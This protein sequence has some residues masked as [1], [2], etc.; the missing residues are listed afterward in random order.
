MTGLRFRRLPC[1]NRLIYSFFARPPPSGR[2]DMFHPLRLLSPAHRPGAPARLL[3]QPLSQRCRETSRRLWL[4]WK[5]RPGHWA[6]TFL[7]DFSF[8]PISPAKYTVHYCLLTSGLLPPEKCS[9]TPG[10]LV[11]PRAPLPL[12]RFHKGLEERRLTSEYWLHH[13]LTRGA[14]T[15]S[16]I[17][18]NLSL[19]VY[20]T[21]IRRRIVPSS[22]CCSEILLRKCRPWASL[23]QEHVTGLEGACC[24]G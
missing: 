3:T 17:P 7:C 9:P 19:P 20:K 23:V 15:S 8:P 11:Q 13:S 5:T 22:E 4:S 10:S 1:C 2:R 6:C 12:A 21:G 14:Y 24:G 18:L 16:L